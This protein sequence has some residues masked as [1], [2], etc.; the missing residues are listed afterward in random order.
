MIF[1]LF[2]II[3]MSAIPSAIMCDAAIN[4]LLSVV[5][6]RTMVRLSDFA[7]SL[8]TSIYDIIPS[9]FDIWHERVNA[10]IFIKNYISYHPPGQV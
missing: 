9:P 2:P 7:F 6:G 1:S 4:V 8:I 10:Y 5:S 3:I